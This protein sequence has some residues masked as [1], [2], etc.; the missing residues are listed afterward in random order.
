MIYGFWAIVMVF[1]ACE[2][3]ERFSHAFDEIDDDIEQFDWNLFP[4]KIQ[5]LL[6]TL[7]INTQQPFEIMCFGSTACIRETFKRVSFFNT[8]KQKLLKNPSK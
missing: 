3:G 5:R 8:K 4:M 6:V 1:F 7:M 2:I